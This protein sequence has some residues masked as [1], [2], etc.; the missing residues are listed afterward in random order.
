MDN[1]KNLQSAGRRKDTEWAVALLLDAQSTG[2]MRHVIR[3]LERQPRALFFPKIG[4]GLE[5]S[6]WLSQLGF[7]WSNRTEEIDSSYDALLV[8]LTRLARETKHSTWTISTA[9]RIRVA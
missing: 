4:L 2:F 7:K 6:F 8:V 1:L 5:V 9:K 3:R